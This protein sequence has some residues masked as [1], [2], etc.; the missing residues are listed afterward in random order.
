MIRFLPMWAAV[1]RY[2]VGEVAFEWAWV[3]S[4][5]YLTRWFT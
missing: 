2:L 5:H 4:L 1:H 3:P